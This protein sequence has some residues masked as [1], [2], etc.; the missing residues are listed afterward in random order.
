MRSKMFG[1]RIPFALSAAI[2]AAGVLS[3]FGEGA[4][5]LVLT[6]GTTTLTDE[7]TVTGLM[8]SG[9]TLST[10]VAPRGASALATAEPPSEFADIHGVAVLSPDGSNPGVIAT[11]GFDAAGGRIETGLTDLV[12]DTTNACVSGSLASGVTSQT[13]LPAS[14]SNKKTGTAITYWKNRRLSD[15]KSVRAIIRPG[16][17]EHVARTC[18]FRNDGTT[19]TVQFQGRTDVVSD[20]YTTLVGVRVTFAQVGD[21]VTAKV[22]NCLYA[23]TDNPDKMCAGECVDLTQFG[24]TNNVYDGVVSTGGYG[25]RAIL[26]GEAKASDIGTGGKGIS[27]ETSIRETVYAGELAKTNQTETFT[28]WR[29]L[30][31]SDVVMMQAEILTSTTW[32]KAHGFFMERPEDGVLR[33]TF[34]RYAG[35]YKENG[36]V[37]GNDFV[38]SSTVEFRQ[39]GTDVTAQLVEAGYRYLQSE[40][41]AAWP[42]A[43]ALP[44]PTSLLYMQNNSY[45]VRNIRVF[46]KPKIDLGGPLTVAGGLK[47]SGGDFLKISSPAVCDT[48]VSGD[49]GVW[50]EGR[51]VGT[52]A[53]TNTL[54]TTTSSTYDGP[55]VFSGGFHVVTNASSFASGS[56]VVLTNGAHVSVYA[57][58]LNTVTCSNGVF[59]VHS[60][61]NL[62]NRNLGSGWCLGKDNEI[63]LFGGTF[64]A[65]SQKHYM[66][67]LTLCDGALV[68]G[69]AF[70]FGYQPSYPHIYSIGT[71]TDVTNRITAGI[72]FMCKNNARSE[73]GTIHAMADLVL[74][75]KVTFDTTA[76]YEGVRVRKRGFGRLILAPTCANVADSSLGALV[77]TV[78]VEVVEGTLRNE[79]ANALLPVNSVEL[80]DGA[81]YESVGAAQ[82]I[83]ALVVDAKTSGTKDGATVRFENG[84]TF[85]LPADGLSIAENALLVL[86][87]DLT[88]TSFRVGETK[89]LPSVTLSRI[90]ARID[91]RLRHVQQDENGY[92]FGPCGMVI[93]IR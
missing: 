80:R 37:V 18:F 59:H 9:E 21:D 30:R 17:R 86:D 50:Y 67:P 78:R 76:G 33:V 42:A 84:G 4:G 75:G 81:V 1:V 69:K 7:L 16:N 13:Y 61:C 5:P 45:N 66:G 46:T 55:T 29:N 56:T 38:V 19:A 41:S 39:V 64:T 77:N 92:L 36:V 68:A 90:R 74:A 26:A 48:M 43:G 27:V 54:Y 10:I 20:H 91:G 6:G 34:Q 51:T 47:L 40:S 32:G 88:E 52:R 62:H 87:G 25:L 70:R 15:V 73:F 22:E 8:F 2:F 57:S 63:F 89:G 65:D 49:G 3:A 14:A 31:L 28:Y 53:I 35:T 85:A 71:R 79:S 60:G 72:K 23:K 83:G 11:D 58:A 12:Y 44:I 24:S 82:E 93:T